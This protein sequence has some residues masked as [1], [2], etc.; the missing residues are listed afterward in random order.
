MAKSPLPP[1]EQV[2]LDLQ[3]AL[4]ALGQTA[5][6]LPFTDDDRAF[7]QELSHRARLLAAAHAARLAAALLRTA[8]PGQGGAIQDQLA[9]LQQSVQRWTGMSRGWYEDRM[10][11]R[12]RVSRVARPDGSTAMEA[13]ERTYGPYR[14]FHWYDDTGKRHTAYLGLIEPA[15]ED[16][17]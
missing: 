10:I 6:A 17:P 8:E 4:A 15:E 5:P 16:E 9:A 13:V 3:A 2:L 1:M 7:A 11:K 14:Y 12:Q